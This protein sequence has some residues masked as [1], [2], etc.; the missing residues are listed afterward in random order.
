MSDCPILP[1]RKETVGLLQTNY[2]EPLTH[3]SN[4]HGNGR[5]RSSQTSFA[6]LD[7]ALAY[8]PPG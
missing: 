3:G 1:G 4:R 7:V 2:A 6:N 5:G 8:V